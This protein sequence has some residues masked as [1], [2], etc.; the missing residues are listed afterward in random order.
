[1]D[2]GPGS[3]AIRSVFHKI[4]LPLNILLKRQLSYKDAKYFPNLFCAS[5]WR[6]FKKPCARM[7]K[8]GLTYA[9]NGKTVRHDGDVIQQRAGCS[10]QR[11]SDATPAAP[12]RQ[13]CLQ[14]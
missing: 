7:K 2:S 4:Y 6:F 5:R 1:M 9:K 14:G 3:F 12:W 10:A 8:R 13:I 11:N